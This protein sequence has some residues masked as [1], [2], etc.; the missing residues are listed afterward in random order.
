MNIFSKVIGVINTSKGNYVLR[1]EKNGVNFSAGQFFSIGHEKLG[2]NR[3]YSVASSSDKSYIDFFIREVEGG[4]FSGKLRKL[5]EG[6]R[7]KILG[8]YGEFYLRNFYPDANFIFFA[9]GTGIAPFISLIDTHKI[10]N[11]TIFHGIREFDDNYNLKKLNNYNLAISRES[12]DQN[13]SDKFQDIKKGR[14]NQFVKNLMVEENMLFFLCGNSLMVSQIYDDLLNKKVKQE[15]I[16]TE[17]F[18]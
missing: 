14:V 6:D 7:V 2:I 10:K 4:A 5:K 1:I 16:F 12:I 8:P 11:Y 18:F 3:E 15:K 13:K 17:I 9:T